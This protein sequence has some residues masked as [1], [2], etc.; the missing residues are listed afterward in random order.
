MRRLLSWGMPAV[1]AQALAPGKR[2]PVAVVGQFASPYFVARSPATVNVQEVRLPSRAPSR[3]VWLATCP[4]P[5]VP[6]TGRIRSLA[7][8]VGAT[9][10][11][12]RRDLRSTVTGNAREPRVN[13]AGAERRTHERSPGSD[14]MSEEK[15]R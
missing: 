8:L 1:Y 3:L 15:L 6:Q 12:P 5:G 2:R 4:T 10:L 14:T 11:L 13:E 9:G 7:A